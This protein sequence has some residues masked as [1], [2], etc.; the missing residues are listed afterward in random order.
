METFRKTRIQRINQL[1]NQS[2]KNDEIGNPILI[3]TYLYELDKIEYNIS[4]KKI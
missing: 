3:S 2:Y 4:N 1:D